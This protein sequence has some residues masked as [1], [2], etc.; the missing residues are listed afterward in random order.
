VLEA[1]VRVG[2]Q[3]SLLLLPV[4]AN[5]VCLPEATWVSTN[6]SAGGFQSGNPDAGT[7]TAAH[8]DAVFHALAPGDTT[9][10]VLVRDVRYELFY[11]SLRKRIGVI[12]VLP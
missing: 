7:H 6:P 1:Q 2:G 10:Y 8:G 12:H 3:V 9:L 5:N 4:G 11:V